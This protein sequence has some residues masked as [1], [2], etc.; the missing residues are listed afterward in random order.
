[1][2]NRVER[3]VEENKQFIH[4]LAACAG[5]GWS[6]KITPHGETFYGC[7][8]IHEDGREFYFYHNTSHNSWD[9]TAYLS[10]DPYSASRASNPAKVKPIGASA[11]KT[12]QQIWRDI[13]RR[14]MPEYLVEFQEHLA[15]LERSA[16][17]HKNH[18]KFLHE[19]EAMIGK[20]FKGRRLGQLEDSL[21][22][23]SNYNMKLTVSHGQLEMALDFRKY[24]ELGIQVLKLL[25]ENV[26]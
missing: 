20:E 9:I 11:T 19:V 5:Q 1:M 16:D 10:R 6:P 4:E 17:H 2:V 7:S 8:L 21:W 23:D 15:Q 13:M 22:L 3:T 24:P 26:K 18:E 25:K 12:P 14:L